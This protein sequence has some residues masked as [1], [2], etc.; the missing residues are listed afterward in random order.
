MV[1]M[2]GKRKQGIN[3]YSKH[4][5]II[6]LTDDVASFNVYAYSKELCART[7]EREF[8]KIRLV[9]PFYQRRISAWRGLQERFVTRAPISRFPRAPLAFRWNCHRHEQAERAEIPFTSGFPSRAG[10]PAL[11]PISLT[12]DPRIFLR[13]FLATKNPRRV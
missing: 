11:S 8:R 4:R 12:A 9:I 2:I 6:T 13:S 3:L 10:A 1:S 7:K 5:R